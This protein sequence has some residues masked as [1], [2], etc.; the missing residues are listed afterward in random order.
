[1]V[2]SYLDGVRFSSTLDGSPVVDLMNLIHAEGLEVTRAAPA[3]GA[4]ETV[5]IPT[6]SLPRFGVE[7]KARPD[8][9]IEGSWSVDGYPFI[10]RHTLDT[11]GII[12][13][14]VFDRWGDPDQTDTFGVHPFGGEIAGL[15][16]LPR[17]D[18]AQIR[19]DGLAL[20]DPTVR[21]ILP[22]Q[23]HRQPVWSAAT[24]STPSRR[25][26]NGWMNAAITYVARLGICLLLLVLPVFA[27][28]ANTIALT[29]EQQELVYFG[30]SRFEEQGLTL[31]EIQFEFF[32]T[33]MDCEGHLGMFFHDTNTLRMCSLDKKTM[34]HELAHG[35]A[36]GVLTEDEKQ[37]FMELRGVASWNGPNGA[38]ED[39][40][41]EH[42][43]EVIA[44]AL[45]DEQNS[46]LFLIDDLNG[47]KK[48]EFRLFSIENS[49]VESLHE[50]FVQLTG[51]EPVFR[52][53]SEWDS[54]ALYADWQTRMSSYSPEARRLAHSMLDPSPALDELGHLACARLPSAAR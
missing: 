11:N 8:S 33:T 13:S 50:S 2:Y 24:T 30:L 52:S 40:G 48:P 22:L 7:W 41:S 35:W 32:S 53:P 12:T 54:V 44:W 47:Q 1:M 26:K 20:R 27:P 34:L 23:D 51:L 6:A 16:D 4:A 18:R 39:C 31:P 19:Q 43:A 28:A 17:L 46:Q 15:E 45:L 3:R 21:R 25:R 42:V 36:R 38:W 49:S 10:N 9:H 5:W 37:A 29:A 14:V